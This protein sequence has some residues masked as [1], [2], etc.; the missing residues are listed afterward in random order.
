[1]LRKAFWRHPSQ[2]SK[3]L[4]LK[5]KFNLFQNLLIYKFFYNLHVKKRLP[6][7]QRLQAPLPSRVRWTSQVLFPFI[8]SVYLG[9]KANKLY[10]VKVYGLGLNKEEGFKR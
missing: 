5:I 10:A 2:N 6:I 7:R 4:Q 8:F 9:S 3:D 1:M